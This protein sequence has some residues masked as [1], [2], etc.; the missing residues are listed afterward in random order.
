MDSGNLESLGRQCR[1]VER[2]EQ[3]KANIICPNCG[4][5]GIIA[6]ETT[7]GERSLISLSR[8]FSE[9]LAKKTPHFIELVCN[10]CGATQVEE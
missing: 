2:M 5:A 4:T 7:R 10:N 6:W 9:R 3:Y 1:V 8:G